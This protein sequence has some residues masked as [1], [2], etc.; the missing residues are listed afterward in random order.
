VAERVGREALDVFIRATLDA[1]RASFEGAIDYAQGVKVQ[2]MLRPPLGCSW[3]V[4][5]PDGLASARL[6][7]LLDKLGALR[8]PRSTQTVVFELWLEVRGA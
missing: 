1:A 2:G 4:T 6:Q 8:A 3:L 5:R 7:P